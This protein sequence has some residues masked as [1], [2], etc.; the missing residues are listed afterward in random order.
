ML[1]T[2]P[3]WIELWYKA[4]NFTQ[5]SGCFLFVSLRKPK[6]QEEVDQEGLGCAGLLSI[7]DLGPYLNTPFGV[8]RVVGEGFD[9]V[10]WG[11]DNS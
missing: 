7:A 3:P 4:P 1:R 11:G 8:F 9:Y 10:L 5:L 2:L 6:D